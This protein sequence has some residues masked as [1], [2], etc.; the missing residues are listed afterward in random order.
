MKNLSLH[1]LIVISFSVLSCNNDDD[2]NPEPQMG[3]FP[4]TIAFTEISGAAV[5]IDFTYDTNN[6]ISSITAPF[7]SFELEYNS[8][9]LINEIIDY[10][11][12][13]VYTMTYDGDILTSITI[14]DSGELIPVSYSNGTYSLNSAVFSS[15]EQNMVV[16]FNGSAITY[17]NIPGPFA[18]LKFQPA[19]LISTEFFPYA[20]YLFSA[21]EIATMEYVFSGVT[22]TF[23]TVR[24][25]NNNIVLAESFDEWGGEGI[26][27][28]IAYE[29]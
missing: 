29:F 2:G 24:D 12:N 23:T 28:A 10:S 9:G 7:A 20:V 17:V 26:D 22:Y 27:Y 3:F 8:N 21:H 19:L 16:D 5:E 25:A 1:F 14:Q 11:E 4:S 13:D 6:R 15:N 18:N